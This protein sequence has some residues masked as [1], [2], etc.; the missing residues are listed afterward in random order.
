M[1]LSDWIKKNETFDM[2][3]ENVILV[4]PTYAWRIPR[5]VR[6]WI[7]KADFSAVKKV[8]FVMTC[9]SEIGYASAYNQ[10]ICS[11]IRC[12]YMGSRDYYARKLCCHV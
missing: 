4:T 6:D 7:R 11:E 3:A 9:G 10:N 8:W 12:E 1:N 2:Q 5:I